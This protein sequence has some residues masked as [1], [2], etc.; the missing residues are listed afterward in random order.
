MKRAD[1]ID[2]VVA[3]V[4][5]PRVESLLMALL[6]QYSP[7][8]SEEPAMSV[9]AEALHDA[10]LSYLRQPV[11]DRE[12]GH[13][14]GNLVVEIGPSPARLMWV[15][16]VDTV[17]PADDE[18]LVPQ[19]D[20]DLVHG[21]GASDMKS[22]CAAMLA[23]LIAVQEAGVSLSR[24]FTAGFVV[25]E[26]EAGDGS[27]ALSRNWKAPI[28]IIGEPTGLALATEH[29]GYW[30]YRLSAEGSRVHAALPELGGSAI[31]AM[32]VW[33]TE[34]CERAGRVDDPERLA[35]NPR[36]IG[37][38]G[39]LFVVAERCEAL[40]DVH[41]AP[42]LD[43]E[44]IGELIE[45]SRRHASAAH[46][47]C[48]L[49]HEMVCDAPGYRAGHADAIGTLNEAFGH[50]DVPL[51]TAAFRSHSDA[52]IFHDAGAVT[53]VCGPGR[54]ELAHTRHEHVSIDEVVKAAKLY[55]AMIC[56]TCM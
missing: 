19:R 44:R 23:A 11:P 13:D 42:D 32:L 5:A 28:T 12:H 27:L 16:H 39:D 1:A 7:S 36:E 31:H 9:I 46:A 45:S 10:H 14:D 40:V 4:D 53:V 18:L 29:Y 54:L 55:A 49:V 51:Q 25:G 43:G 17:P 22:G 30:E 21:L 47:R 8:F 56:T 6:E 50:A 41:A 38:G 2:A 20:G 26:E 34:I 37:G 3:R 52:P 48:T 35:V 24:G 15:G 33:L